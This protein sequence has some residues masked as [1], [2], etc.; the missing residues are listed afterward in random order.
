MLGRVKALLSTKN[1]LCWLCCT[2]GAFPNCNNPP[3]GNRK[4]VHHAIPHLWNT[5]FF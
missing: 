1:H 5:N 2:P 3:L 4:T